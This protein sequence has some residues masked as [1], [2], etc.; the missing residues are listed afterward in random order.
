[1]T[2][3][4]R[5]SSLSSW[6]PCA[7]RHL[8][9]L[10]SAPRALWTRGTSL[11]LG[12]MSRRLGRPDDSAASRCAMSRRRVRSPPSS[13]STIR[14]RRRTCARRSLGSFTTS[15][16]RPA[17]SPER[18]QASVGRLTSGRTPRASSLV[19]R[20]NWLSREWYGP[21]RAPRPDERGRRAVYLMPMT[22]E[23]GP[24]RGSTR[25]TEK[26]ASFIQP[27]QSAPV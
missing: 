27:E 14:R 9:W 3:T 2:L 1:M 10:S 4:S 13:C 12:E 20:G 24:T 18:P 8:P 21:K 11:G 16:G 25:V 22:I 19:T 17:R 6:G 23:S 26:P 7:T 5:G 15:L